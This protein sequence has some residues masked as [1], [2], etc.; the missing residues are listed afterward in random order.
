MNILNDI[1]SLFIILLITS[2]IYA[3]Y[4][5]FK[6]IKKENEE[7]KRVINRNELREELTTFKDSLI[8]SLKLNDASETHTVPLLSNFSEAELQVGKS[9]IQGKTS[10]EIAGERGT[11]TSTINNQIEA[12]R[13]KCGAVNRTALVVYLLKNGLV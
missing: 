6:S 13:A 4:D 9:L 3:I 10:A 7:F 2:A 11:T 8:T 12:M 1:S 5:R